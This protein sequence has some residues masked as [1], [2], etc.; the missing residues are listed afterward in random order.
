MTP[1]TAF[2]QKA[3]KM[4]SMGLFVRQG[5]NRSDTERYREDFQRSMADKDAISCQIFGGTQY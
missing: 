4:K 3:D 2:P 5:E 1:G